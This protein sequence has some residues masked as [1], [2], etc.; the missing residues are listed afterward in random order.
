MKTTE[1]RTHFESLSALLDGELDGEE[2]AALEAHL[3]HCPSCLEELQSL[4]SSLEIFEGNLPRLPLGDQI[5]HEIQAEIQGDLG[6]RVPAPSPPAPAPRWP[7]RW[8]PLTAVAGLGMYLALAPY[9][10]SPRPEPD[11]VQRFNSFIESRE[12]SPQA[13]VSVDDPG[14]DENPFRETLELDSNPFSVE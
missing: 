11:L 14:W 12:S 1:C 2:K 8:I 6:I 10:E 9:W 4:K 7:Y 3:N 5:W 13:P